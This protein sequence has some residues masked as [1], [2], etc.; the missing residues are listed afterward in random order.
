MRVAIF[1]DIHGNIQVLKAIV[2][3]IKKNNIDKVYC[4]GD[5]IAIGPNSRECL[6]MIIENNINMVLGNHEL[7]Y[8][9]GI[10]IDDKMGDGEKEHYCWVKSLLNDEHR[11]FLSKCELQIKEK[12]KGINICYQHFLFNNDNCE[13]PFCDVKIA[14]DGSIAERVSLLDADLTFIGHEHKAFEIDKLSKKLIDVG[15]SGCMKDEH[16]FYTILTI[17]EDG[18]NIEKKYLVYDREEFEENFRNIEYPDK[19]FLNKIFFGVDV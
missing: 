12:I 17:D 13:Y 3:D 5:V 7:Y 4:L 10:G 2:E 15:S 14:R 1:S 9:N 6:D 19:E 18:F 11:Y 16:T 8:L